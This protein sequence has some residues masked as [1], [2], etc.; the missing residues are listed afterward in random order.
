MTEH[1]EAG[2]A[3]RAPAILTGVRRVVIVALVVLAACCSPGRQAPE[4]GGGSTPQADRL[5]QI[6]SLLEAFNSHDAGR[7]AECLAATF[8]WSRGS[9]PLIAGRGDVAA[10]LQDLF[11]ALP[12]VSLTTTRLTALE[13][14]AVAVEWVLEGTQ[15]G[16]WTLID[17]PEPV[18]PSRHAVRVTGAD[19]FR[20]D[21]GGEIESDDARIDVAAL[22]D[23]ISGPAAPASAPAGLRSLAE[24]YTA[25][26]NSRNP[27]TVAAF[28]APDGSLTIN[29]GTPSVGRGAIAGVARGFMTAF[30]DLKLTMDDVLAQGDRAVYQWTFEG[31]N[32]GPGGTGHRVRFSGFEVWR[33]GADGLVAESQGHYDTL[34]Y[35]QQ[36]AQGVGAD[37]R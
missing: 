4:D 21:P 26:W 32:T 9:G 14:A 25:A 20:F 11:R 23:Q 7:A 18:P 1:V 27:A 34:V 6:R 12:D 3:A 36:L 5:D 16:A 22:V 28:F 31:T 15:L 30:P 17:R 29:G 2:A 13:P 10:R 19:L 8:T 24:R 37:G 33:V 35:R